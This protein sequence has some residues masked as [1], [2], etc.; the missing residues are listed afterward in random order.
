MDSF[1]RKQQYKISEKAF[2]LTFLKILNVVRI[3]C[4]MS[5]VFLIT[6][7]ERLSI[8]FGPQKAHGRIT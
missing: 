4:Y 6:Q 7:N 2:Q 3:L 5:D 1:Y 8:K